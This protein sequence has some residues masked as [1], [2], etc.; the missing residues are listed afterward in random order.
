MAHSVWLKMR[1]GH[2]V[3]IHQV[4]RLFM[5]IICYTTYCMMNNAYFCAVKHKNNHKMKLLIRC[6]IKGLRM[7]GDNQL[8]IWNK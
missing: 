5:K 7:M 6:L 2:P 1:T 8:Q 4:L 3:D